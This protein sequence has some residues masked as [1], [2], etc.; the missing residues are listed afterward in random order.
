LLAIHGPVAQFYSDAAALQKV[1][2]LLQFAAQSFVN[3]KI[4]G[5][6]DPDQ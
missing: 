1:A 6:I 5:V 4:R 3:G 2:L